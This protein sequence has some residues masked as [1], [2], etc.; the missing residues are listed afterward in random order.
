MAAGD[1]V[2]LAQAHRRLGIDIA[3]TDDDA[4]LAELIT[5]V[6]DWIADY[7]RPAYLIAETAQ[8]FYL[9]TTAGS[10]IPFPRGIRT[11]TSLSIASSSQPDDG[12]GTYVAVAA[13]DIY[14]RPAIQ[15]RKPGW[16][17]TA[18]VL[19]GAT[20]RLVTAKN[21][22]KLVGD[23]GFSAVPAR[24][25]EVALNAIS[26]AYV[27]RARQAGGVIGEDDTPVAPWAEYFGKGSPQRATLA[28][29][30]AGAGIA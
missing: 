28:R 13:T 7:V 22:A 9:D 20:G 24:V 10:V 15:D 3:D 30:R 5:D 8:T 21:G 12:S 29:F 11:V 16:P 26:Q 6:S 23:T 4:L 25:Q 1:L 18:I 14:L 2:T 19:A 17:A 27:T